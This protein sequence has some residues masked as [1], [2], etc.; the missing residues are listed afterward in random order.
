MLET[1]YNKY[2]TISSEKKSRDINKEKFKTRLSKMSVSKKTH[3]SR[4]QPY[5]LSRQ[6]AQNS[7]SSL[8]TSHQRS[9]RAFSSY[10]ISYFSNT[11]SIWNV[12]IL[13]LPGWEIFLKWVQCPATAWSICLSK[14]HRHIL[15][16]C[17]WLSSLLPTCDCMIGIHSWNQPGVFAGLLVIGLCC[18]SSKQLELECANSSE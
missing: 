14:I 9:Q 1:I 2:D 12:P 6:P 11:Y 15:W 7:I 10:P 3:S 8:H 17:H 5:N 16:S 18:F 13:L 4:N